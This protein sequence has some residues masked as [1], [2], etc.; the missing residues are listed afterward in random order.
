MLSAQVSPDDRSKDPSDSGDSACYLECWRKR[1]ASIQNDV[2]PGPL[3]VAKPHPGRIVTEEEFLRWRDEETRAEWVDGEVV[4]MSPASVIH[5]RLTRFLLSL[6]QDYVQEL[7]LG[8][9]FGTE[10][11][12]RINSRRRLP[13]VLFV[14]ADRSERLQENH[15]EGAPNLII[16]VV[17]EDSVDRDWRVKYLD[18]QAGGVEEYWVVDPLYRRVEAYSLDAGKTYRSITPVDGR[19]ASR[20]VPGFYLRPDWLWQEQLPKV[21]A[22]LKELLGKP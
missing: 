12:V 7:G 6:L 14:A 16:E 15:F 20:V 13:D 22:V 10:L 2:G 4:V 3:A 21:P 5:N 18:Y 11:S 8:E 19:V 9:A 17:S 1:M